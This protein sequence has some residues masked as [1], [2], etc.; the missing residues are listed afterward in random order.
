MLSILTPDNH[1]KCPRTYDR[2]STVCPA[3][4]RKN[5]M[6]QRA[7]AKETL[8]LYG[9]QANLDKYN[10]ERESVPTA[11]ELRQPLLYGPN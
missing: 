1:Q 7:L 4:V 2:W 8:L 9:S 10:R 5:Q 11:V 6:I 3:L